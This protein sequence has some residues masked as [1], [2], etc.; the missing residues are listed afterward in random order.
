MFLVQMDRQ[1]EG[2]EDEKPAGRC[3]LNRGVG[4]MIH[5]CK[6]DKMRAQVGQQHTRQPRFPAN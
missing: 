4:D 5:E 6:V 2:Q 1:D 3:C